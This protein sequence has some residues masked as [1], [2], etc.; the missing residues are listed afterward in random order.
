MLNRKDNMNSTM[1]LPENYENMNPENFMLEFAK[2]NNINLAPKDKRENASR[3][4][5]RMIKLCTGTTEED[6]WI[7]IGAR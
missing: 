5:N 3:Y 2:I 7:G 6:Y 4:K 1:Q